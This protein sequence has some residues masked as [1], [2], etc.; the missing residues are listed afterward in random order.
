ML[1]KLLLLRLGLRL[2]SM[3]EAHPAL[4]AGS[5]AKSG[6]RIEILLRVKD[7]G[8]SG[9]SGSIRGVRSGFQSSGYYR[10]DSIRDPN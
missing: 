5:Y 4:E 6:F 8:E 1:S 3:P 2:D 7:L 9:V 10:K